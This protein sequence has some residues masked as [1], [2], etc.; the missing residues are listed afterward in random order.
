MARVWSRK[1]Y[2]R[3]FT[4]PHGVTCGQLIVGW[5]VDWS[6][7]RFNVVSVRITHFLAVT[8]QSLHLG[9]PA[10]SPRVK[11]NKTLHRIPSYA[12]LALR[13]TLRAVLLRSFDDLPTVVDSSPRG[14]TSFYI[15]HRLLEVEN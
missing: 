7:I 3:S 4:A 15:L 11:C 1:P 2:D 13:A 12:H 9:L 14:F 5:R 8:S 10:C 6:L